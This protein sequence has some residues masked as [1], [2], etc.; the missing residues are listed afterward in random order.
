MSAARRHVARVIDQ[1]AQ[2]EDAVVGHAVEKRRELRAGEEEAFEAGLL[3]QSRIERAEPA[4]HHRELLALQ[5]L[6]EFQPLVADGIVG[7]HGFP[8]GLRITCMP[9]RSTLKYATGA[10]NM[11]CMDAR[12]EEA[13]RMRRRSSHEGW[14]RSG[15]AL[16]ERLLGV[17]LIGSLAHGGFSPRYSDID[18][19]LMAEGGLSH[20]DLEAHAAA[21]AVALSPRAAPKLSLFWADRAFDDRAAFR[22]S[23][24]SITSIMRAALSASASACVRGAHRLRRDPRVSPRAAARQLGRSRARNSPPPPPPR[25]IRRTT[26]PISAALLYPARLLL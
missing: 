22:R 2:T 16:G 13:A 5:Q 7:V 6:A 26:S 18:L 24:G 3:R 12:A 21:A 14:P 23:T 11:R 25:C 19:A 9:P 20:G 8:L 15:S 1:V 4:R 10:A 17:Y